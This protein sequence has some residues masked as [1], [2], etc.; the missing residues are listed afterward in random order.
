MSLLGVTVPRGDVRVAP[1]E[2]PLPD[3]LHCAL[4]HP[5]L[6]LYRLRWGKRGDDLFFDQASVAALVLPNARAVKTYFQRSKTLSSVYSAA[7][8]GWCS[9][10][11]KGAVGRGGAR[12][13]TY[14]RVETLRFY[15]MEVMAERTCLTPWASKRR[16]LLPQQNQVGVDSLGSSS[17]GSG[18]SDSGDSD[19]DS[20]DDEKVVA[21]AEEVFVAAEIATFRARQQISNPLLVT[22]CGMRGTSVEATLLAYFRSKGGPSVSFKRALDEMQHQAMQPGPQ[23][24][25]ATYQPAVRRANPDTRGAK[26]RR[27]Q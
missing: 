23:L 2:Y 19:S 25:V 10:S 26:C 7:Q 1:A 11:V 14:V 4:F 5:K 18:D 13:V 12:Q 17:G 3:R 24:N 6:A 27:L 22:L 20:D 21:S 8:N 16:R 15:F 9:A